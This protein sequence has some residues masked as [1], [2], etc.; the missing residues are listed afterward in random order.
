M[1]NPRIDGLLQHV[2]A[3]L[4]ERKF[5]SDAELLDRFIVHGDEKAFAALMQRH[6]PLVLGVCRRVL[7]H[8]QDA[9]D[10]FQATFLVLARRAGAIRR[11]ASLASWLYGVAY[12][13][14]LKAQA[15]AA[16]RSLHEKQLPPPAPRDSAADVT[17]G[18][19]RQVLDEELAR[20]PEK[21]RAPL[22]LCYFNGQTQDEASRLLGCKARTFKAR[23][24]RARGLLRGRLERRGLTLSTALVGPLLGPEVPSASTVLCQSTVQAAKL[25]AARGALSGAVSVRVLALVEGGLRAMFVTKLLVVSVALS[26]LAFLAGGA[27]LVASRAGPTTAIPVT[28]PAENTEQGQL[29]DR[30]GDPLPQ[31]AIARLGT[32]RYRYQAIGAAFLPDDETVVSAKEDGAIQLW[33]AHT[34]RLVREIKPGQLQIRRAFAVSRDGKSVAVSGSLSEPPNFVWRSVVRVYDVSTGKEVRTF[35][36]DLRDGVETLALTPDGKFLLTLGGEG[37]LRVE[38]VATGLELLEHQFPGDIQPHLALSR[39]GSTLALASGPN[40]R[41]LFVWK[42]QTA[43]EPRE[44]RTAAGYRGG[45]VAFSADGKL[46]ADCSDIDPVVRI[47]DVQSAR[48]LRKLQLPDL[49]SYRH[50]HIVF[51]PDGKMM[52]ASGIS[53]NG[54]NSAVHLWNPVTGEFLRRLDLGGGPLD[55]SS[56]G[57][58]LVDGSRVWD[59]VAGRELSANDQAPWGEVLR[60]ATGDRGLVVTICGEKEI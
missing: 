57:R 8:D 30:W 24:A 18:E 14:A 35:E 55:F 11:R 52:A 29:T 60:I 1:A 59:F 51:S 25:F 39:D 17:W 38:E 47:W 43:E 5:G 44:F 27:A 56:N 3:A 10:V 53:A 34:G 9:E 50:G 48:L 32:V 26:A 45:R 7:R 13:L 54:L 15:A 20:L 58:L 41:K 23:L 33:A 16:R 37:K 21:F 4:T 19:L 46:L 42:W 22:L 12:R 31:G 36:R 40:S 6:A 49:E 2:R 28:A